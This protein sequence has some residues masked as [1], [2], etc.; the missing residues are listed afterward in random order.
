M[1][2]NEKTNYIVINKKINKESLVAFGA[3]ALTA[4]VAVCA[5]KSDN[6]E[7]IAEAALKTTTSLASFYCLYTFLRK[8]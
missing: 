5:I 8:I 4:T 2:S 6:P 7:K 3:G 1:S